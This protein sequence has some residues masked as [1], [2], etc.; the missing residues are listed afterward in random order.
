MADHK[1]PG[2]A[3]PDQ[4]AADPAAL[5]LSP[6]P[7][8]HPTAEPH[9]DPAQRAP[10]PAQVAPAAAADRQSAGAPYR[11][12]QKPTP[13]RRATPRKP[14]A[15][16]TTRTKPR[17]KAGI[18]PDAI[19]ASASA[20]ASVDQPDNWSPSAGRRTS[21]FRL[22]GP[23]LVLA[24]EAEADHD[25]RGRRHANGHADLVVGKQPRDHR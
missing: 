3:R 13:P 18:A 14:A 10:S 4:R 21:G 24:E 15:H 7:G 12:H 6:L 16:P 19:S 9:T 20:S 1:H 8:T 2:P 25:Q 17:T 11:A 5:P 22:D 23:H